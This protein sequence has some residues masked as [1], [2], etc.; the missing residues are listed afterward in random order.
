MKLIH[1]TKGDGLSLNVIVIAVIAILVLV[2]LAVIFFNQMG[3]FDRGV[4]SCSGQCVLEANSCQSQTPIAI[5][6]SC[7]LPGGGSGNYCCTAMPTS[8]P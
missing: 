8:N 6:M 1:N 2:V 5:P 7:E 3:T 4:T